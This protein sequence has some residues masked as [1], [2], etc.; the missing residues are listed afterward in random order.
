MRKAAF[1]QASGWERAHIEEALK[2]TDIAAD[3]FDH[4]LDGAHL[5]S[6]CDY[7]IVSVFVGSRVDKAVIDSFP[8]LK[9]ITTRST[10]FD[11]V[12]CA[13]AASKGIALGY[14]PSY[15]ENTVA[16]FTMGLM[17]TLS[18][19]LYKGID[20]IKETS[21]FTCEGLE[22]FDL[23]GKTLGIIGT[24]RIG[25]HVI[26]MAQGFGMRIAAYDP[27]PREDLAQQLGFSY[28]PL[29]EL[30][31]SS[32]IVSLHVPYMPATHHMINKE[33][34]AKVK[35]GAY[36]INTARGPLVETEALLAA[37]QDGTLAGAALDVLEEEG[38]IKDEMGYLMRA[39]GSQPADF[40]TVLE[41]HVLMDL[42]NVVITPHNAFNTREAK[43]RILETDLAN[44]RAF[45]EKGVVQE[46]IAVQA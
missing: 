12:D 39:E 27:Y 41:D 13:Y 46:A 22:G 40:K 20:R 15:G 32:D 28:V 36:L 45:C 3:F 44:I 17:L 16:E 11:H 5:P 10:G 35:K 42:P 21:E 37:L 29:D 26:R 24:G 18:R 30:L 38:A 7:E 43:I 9:L 33:A 25:Q 1:F 31:A 2:G 19:K 6:S 14:V 8:S 23:K 4:E 34:L